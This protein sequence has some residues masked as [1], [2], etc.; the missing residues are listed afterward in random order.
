[1]EC[2]SSGGVVSLLNFSHSRECVTTLAVVLANIALETTDAV[3]LCM[4]Q[5]TNLEVSVQA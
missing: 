1:M 4:I 5:L 2:L 3:F